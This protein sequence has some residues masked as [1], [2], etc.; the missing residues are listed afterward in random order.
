MPMVNL[1]VLLFWCVREARCSGCGIPARLFLGG[2]LLFP[3][4]NYA[5]AAA[6]DE[7]GNWFND[8]YFQV[9]SAIP[10]CPQPLGPFLTKDAANAEGH[11]RVERGTSCYLAGECKKP[12]AYLYDADIASAVREA[13]NDSALLSDSTIWITVKRRFV[14]IEGCRAVNQP[15]GDLEA[16]IRAIPDVQL[17]L[18]NIWSKEKPKPPYSLMPRAAALSEP[19]PKH[20]S[21]Q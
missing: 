14:W 15:L 17:V 18:V 8:P 21:A 20:N 16:R 9:R 6:N 13:F 19:T 11:Y 5:F 12:N 2:L 10:D 4:A 3:S 1:L 7:L